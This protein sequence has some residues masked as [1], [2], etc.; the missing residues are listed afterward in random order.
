MHYHST[1]GR[2]WERGCGVWG[3]WLGGCWGTHPH[4]VLCVGSV[5]L[6]NLTVAGASFVV[7]QSVNGQH[8][9]Y[10]QL[11]FTLNSTPVDIFVFSLDSDRETLGKVSEVER[12]GSPANETDNLTPQAF[13]HGMY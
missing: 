5:P 2:T 10:S 7:V 1:G 13:N 9:L 6:Q 3:V 8:N 12:N 11:L 4:K